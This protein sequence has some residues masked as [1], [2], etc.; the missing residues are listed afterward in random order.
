MDGDISKGKRLNFHFSRC[1]YYVFKV[2][3]GGGCCDLG[4]VLVGLETDTSAQKE[5]YFELYEAGLAPK[6]K[7]ERDVN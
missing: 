6:Q 1:S 4:V 5:Y 2:P 7:K 3:I